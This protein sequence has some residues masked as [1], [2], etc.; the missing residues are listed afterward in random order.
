MSEK[1]NSLYQ[2]EVSDE[3]MNQIAAGNDPETMAKKDLADLIHHYRD[4]AQKLTNSG[5]YNGGSGIGPS[6]DACNSCA[7]SLLEV[8][9]RRFPEN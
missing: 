2:A 8:Y 4:M 6:I 7:D 5:I 1:K 9:L 3:L